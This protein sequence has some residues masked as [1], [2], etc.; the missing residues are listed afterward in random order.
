[1]YAHVP[2]FSPP[3]VKLLRKMDFTTLKKLIL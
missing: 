1:M 3:L 2:A